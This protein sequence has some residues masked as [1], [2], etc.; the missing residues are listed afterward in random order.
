MLKNEE[1]KDV[2][3]CIYF[4]PMEAEEYTDDGI[5]YIIETF[6]CSHPDRIKEEC[7]YLNAAK[8]KLFEVEV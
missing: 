8:C 5:T 1:I 6:E 3:S 2:W 7:E 4:I